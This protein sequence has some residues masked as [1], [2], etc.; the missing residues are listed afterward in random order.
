MSASIA[1]QALAVPV[2]PVADLAR[3]LAWYGRLGFITATEFLVDGGLSNAYVTPLD[4]D[5]E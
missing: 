2:L 5:F 4:A 3:S 1:P